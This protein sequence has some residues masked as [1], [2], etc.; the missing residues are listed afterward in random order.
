ML[1]SG[2]GQA[3]LEASSRPPLPASNVRDDRDTPLLEEAECGGDNHVFPKNESRIF[4]AGGLDTI[5]GNQ[6][7]GKSVQASSSRGCRI[8]LEAGQIWVG[9]H[10][11]KLSSDRCSVR[12]DILY[13][14]RAVG[15]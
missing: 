14:D 1:S 10:R 7:T 11:S 12:P 2:A 13:E 15:R 6:T 4:F 3:A 9:D 8:L 5:S